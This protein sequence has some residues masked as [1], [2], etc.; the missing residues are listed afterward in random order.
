MFFVVS[1]NIAIVERKERI[2]VMANFTPGNQ[3][4]Q[5]VVDHLESHTE[6]L[7]NLPC[8]THAEKIQANCDFRH[9]AIGAYVVIGCL[10]GG[11]IFGLIWT[12]Y[13][14]TGQ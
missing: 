1:I 10:I 4:E 14:G 9:K 11:G 7:K 2:V 3:F 13:K 5:F 6:K 12:I 8:K